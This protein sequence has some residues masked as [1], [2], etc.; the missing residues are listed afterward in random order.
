M[1][2]IAGHCSMQNK[3]IQLYP[4][5]GFNKNVKTS[6][7]YI[8][9][10]W[11]GILARIF[12]LC[13]VL[14]SGKKKKLLIWNFPIFWQKFLFFL[15]DHFIWIRSNTENPGIYIYIYIFAF[16]SVLHSW[17]VQAFQSVLCWPWVCCMAVF[18]TWTSFPNVNNHSHKSVWTCMCWN[19]WM[20]LITKVPVLKATTEHG[21]I[22]W[23][24]DTQNILWLYISNI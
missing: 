24:E 4:W 12:Y 14:S 13:F 20:V 9:F 6:H 5:N 16:C 7:I 11:F 15:V 18:G 19:H 1:T 23:L 8:F 3:Q 22:L 10:W 2:N 21:C 17:V